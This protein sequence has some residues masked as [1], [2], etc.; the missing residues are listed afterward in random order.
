MTKWRHL[1]RAGAKMIQNGQNMTQIFIE[2][3]QKFGHQFCLR[4]MLDTV[5]PSTF[6]E[7]ARN[8]V[9]RRLLVRRS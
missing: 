5:T 9:E 4:D 3:G 8:F 1:A 7:K 2:I 6:D